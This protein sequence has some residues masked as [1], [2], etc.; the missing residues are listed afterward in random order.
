MPNW[1]SFRPNQAP[2]AVKKSRAIVLNRLCFCDYAY[3]LYVSVLFRVDRLLF[4][5]LET[6]EDNRFTLVQTQVN[7]QRE[8]LE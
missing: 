1:V 8:A 6:I 4:S 5:V 3:E 7:M 2:F